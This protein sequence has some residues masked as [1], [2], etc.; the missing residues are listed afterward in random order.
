MGK[1]FK[2]NIQTINISFKIQNIA[3]P[4]TY[5]VLKKIKI[6][7]KSLPT[8]PTLFS[9]EIRITVFH[10]IYFFRPKIYNVIL[11]II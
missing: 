8:N 10:T 2:L 4:K 11:F 6:K 3:S 7:K 9:H 1:L 5:S